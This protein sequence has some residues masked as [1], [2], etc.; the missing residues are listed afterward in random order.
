[1]RNAVNFRGLTAAIVGCFL[2]AMTPAW[3]QAPSFTI[4]TIAGNGV[5]GYSGDGAPATSAELFNPRGI[6]SDPAG[7]VYFCDFN[8]NRVREVTTAG[9]ITTVAGTGVAGYNGDNIPGTSA[10]LNS[11]YRVALDAAGNLYISDSGNNRIRMLSPNGIIT[12]VAGNG[13]RSYSG[14]G[15]SAL[16]ASLD[17]PEDAVVDAPGN[18]YIA[19][20]GNNL[21]RKVDT[22]GN[23]TTIAG[24]GSPG[25]SGDGGPATQASLFVPVSLALDP[26]GNLFFSDQGNNV[27]RKVDIGGNITT[28]A[29]SGVYG[30]GGDGGPATNAAFNSPAGVALDAA[31]NLYIVDDANN[32]LRAVLADGTII[33]VAGNGTAGSGGDGGPATSAELNQPLSVAVGTF[34]DVY[35]ADY[36]NDR[37]RHLTPLA[38]TIG[39]MANAFGNVKLFA[40]NTWV[41][42]KGTDLAPAGDSRMWQASDF[43]NGQMPV[44]LDGV[45]VTMNGENAYVYYVSPT[46]VNVLTPPDLAP[47][48]VQV[49]VTNGGTQSAI[50]SIEAQTDSPSFFVVGTNSYVLAVHADGSGI[51]PAS[52]NPG[53]TT[54]AQPGETVALFANG[55]GP[56]SQT[57]I[58]GSS[59]QSG[60]LPALPAVTIGGVAATVLSAG[61]ISPGLYQF[62]VVVPSSVPNGDSAIVAAYQ[63]FTTQPG[64]LFTVQQ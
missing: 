63:G 1:M 32:S 55:F 15:G 41:L 26:G 45:G 31:G 57:I 34:G 24:N 61:L 16:S 47:G 38:A 29:G 20:S 6:A 36:L 35:I 21:I 60:D 59:T 8:N 30:F 64:V 28:F 58:G 23:I 2:Y 5:Q 14:D 42:I 19:D 49:Q 40:S 9:I 4:S 22:N 11:P 13:S 10:Q 17:Y 12:T 3:S 25:Y 7:N 53:Q 44:S 48:L 46:Q 51:G 54:P 52:L 43:V 39:F 56:S 62:N 18:I 37:V 50:A 27:V 33:T